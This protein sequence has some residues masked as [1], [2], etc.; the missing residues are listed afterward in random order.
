M[1]LNA[2]KSMLGLGSNYH[3]AATLYT[4]LVTQARSP[5]FYTA[6]GVEDSIR[7]RFDMILLH[8]HLLTTT[9]EERGPKGT[10]M[11][12]SLQEIMVN[13][14][15]RSLRE[16]GVGDMSVGKKMKDLAGAW[17]GRRLAYDE[18]KTLETYAA[19][20]ARN[21]YESEDVTAAAHALA[22]YGQECLRTLSG[23][24][25]ADLFKAKLTF[26]PIVVSQA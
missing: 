23:L 1:L 25:D 3:S 9:L 5:E 14:L 7:G 19:A 15:D 13:D 26:A 8:M 2:L 24:H 10:E 18:A 20:I 16:M 4:V 17:F 12:R 22:R 6:L 11:S 21:V